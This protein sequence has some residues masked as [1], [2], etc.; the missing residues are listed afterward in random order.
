MEP[1]VQPRVVFIADS[2]GVY[3]LHHGSIDRVFFNYSHFGE[4]PHA[5]FLRARHVIRD[6]PGVRVLVM[7]MDPY[8]VG[9]QR[10]YRP[11]PSSRGFY[12]ALLYSSLQDIEEIVSPAR[13]DLTRNVMGF[14]FPLSIWWERIDFWGAIRQSLT[15]VGLLNDLPPSR[16][17]N[18]CGDLVTQEPAMSELSA[19]ER[20]KASR[21]SALIRY[22]DNAFDPELARKYMDFIAYASSHGITVVGIRFPDTMEYRELAQNILDVRAEKFLTSL[23][24]PIL[25]YRNAFDDLSNRDTYF[26]D[27]EHLTSIGADLLSTRLAHDIRRIIDLPPAAQRSCNTSEPFHA[28]SWPYEIP[29]RRLVELFGPA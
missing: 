26:I 18:V 16:Y 23:G 9:R 3:S 21:E 28:T 13:N 24:V 15:T 20:A 11:L 6:K 27:A 29:W 19:L 4:F 17:L 12:E 7:Q 5:Q 8:V 14:L 1:D 2:R 25:D 10:A 22:R